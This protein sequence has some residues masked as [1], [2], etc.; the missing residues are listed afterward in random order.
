MSI[1]T[2]LD[3]LLHEKKLFELESLTTGSDT[4]RKMIVSPHIAAVVSPPF[5]D[6]EE[7]LRLG[8]FRGWLDAF[9]E[10]CELSVAEDPH[11]KPPDAMLARTDPTE[12]EF[13][14]IRVTEPEDTAGLRSLGGF[15]GLDEFIALIWDFR[16]AIP[17]FD[18]EVDQVR[19][20]WR[21]LF[22][23]K[24]PYHGVSLD[25][26]LTNYRAV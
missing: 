24:K 13:W 17:V 18:D 22:G 2:I 15:F 25:A 8:E 4:A 12:D 26:Y 21:D 14:S 10:G 5:P 1:N 9:M 7:G 20:A 19:N 6:T 11:Q 16:E 3:T 23:S